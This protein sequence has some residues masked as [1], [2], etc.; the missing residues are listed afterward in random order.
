VT[1][2]TL[3]AETSTIKLTSVLT[4]N[5][6][7]D[8]G[9]LTYNNFW[10]ATTGSFAV[11][12]SGSNTFNDFRIDGGRQVNFTNSTT[13]TMASLTVPSTPGNVV[14]LRNSS[15]TTH[16]TLAKSGGG[17]ISVDYM[18]V[19]YLTG[20]PDTTWYMGTHSTDGGSNTN[21]YFT[22]APE[23]STRSRII[24]IN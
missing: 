7:F 22:D 14:T 21:I 20:S 13:Q 8:G 10:N 23:P 24:I 12:I 19:N 16:A 17:T 18:D 11:V 3:Y 1:G 6:T 5:R 15:G 2:L 9:G 4:T